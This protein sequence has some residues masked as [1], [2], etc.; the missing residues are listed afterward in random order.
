MLELNSWIHIGK[1]EQYDELHNFPIFAGQKQDGDKINAPV[2]GTDAGT[3][4][5]TN[6]S[7]TGISVISLGKCINLHT[8]CTQQL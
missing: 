2:H 7:S 4:S 5:T 1:Q 3:Y 6:D 8:Q